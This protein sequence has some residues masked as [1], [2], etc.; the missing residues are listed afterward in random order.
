[1][2]SSPY[3]SCSRGWT[4]YLQTLLLWLVC[5]QLIVMTR[6]SQFKAFIPRHNDTSGMMVCRGNVDMKTGIEEH[7]KDTRF[8]RILVHIGYLA[9]GCNRCIYG[10]NSIRED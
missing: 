9:P 8:C 3:F 2:H 5:C 6:L 1:M 4:P 10:L 7:S